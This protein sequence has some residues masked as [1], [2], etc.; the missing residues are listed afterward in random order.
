MDT[1]RD[2]SRKLATPRM[3]TLI[4]S[5]SLPCSTFSSFSLHACC[6]CLES[7]PILLSGHSQSPYMGRYGGA[8]T[9]AGWGED[10]WTGP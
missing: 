4:R 2:D 7:L 5:R 9:A 8:P 6:Y 3:D 10:S 1:E